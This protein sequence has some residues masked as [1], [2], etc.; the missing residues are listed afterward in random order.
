MC[1][2]LLA[3]S[4]ALPT[5]WLHLRGLL[6]AT[7]AEGP[8]WGLGRGK[9]RFPGTSLASAAWLAYCWRAGAQ[10]EVQRQCS[11]WKPAGAVWQG[12]RG[13]AINPLGS[14]HTGL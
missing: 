13:G 6:L 4:D 1:V 12:L 7:Y 9:G 14:Y 3:G 10:G 11:A 2:S 8:P 5:G